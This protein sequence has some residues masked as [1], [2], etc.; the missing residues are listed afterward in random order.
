MFFFFFGF[1]GFGFWFFLVC[2]FRGPSDVILMF[3]VFFRCVIVCFDVIFI[4]GVSV[5]CCFGVG[6]R[7][8]S[9]WGRVA[10]WG[11]CE[12]LRLLFFFF[13]L[14]FFIFFVVFQCLY[15]NPH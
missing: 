9:R 8:W 14:F 15:T 7:F 13:F 3:D 2:C 6:G 1:F 10:N 12:L 5:F 11:V 4:L